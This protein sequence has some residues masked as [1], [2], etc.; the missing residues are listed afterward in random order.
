MSVRYAA[1]AVIDGYAFP[2]E[3]KLSENNK[4]SWPKVTEPGSSSGGGN[5]KA[6][7]TNSKR[8][9]YS[10]LLKPPEST[11]QWVLVGQVNDKT[12][13]RYLKSEPHETPF[14]WTKQPF[15]TSFYFIYY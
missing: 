12:E 11:D 4:V 1:T 13:W 14:S 7:T 9:I 15:L 2:S 8:V 6:S 5:N 3:P 10:A